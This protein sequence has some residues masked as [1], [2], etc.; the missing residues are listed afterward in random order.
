MCAEH[1]RWG[2]LSVLQNALRNSLTDPEPLL[3]HLLPVKNAVDKIMS[4]GSVEDGSDQ[5]TKQGAGLF[6]RCVVQPYA[7]KTLKAKNA[8]CGPLARFLL[9]FLN[10]ITE[11]MAN[12]V[13]SI[14][15]KNKQYKEE[16]S[17]VEEVLENPKRG[18]RLDA[19]CETMS[20]D[21]LVELLTVDGLESMDIDAVVGLLRQSIAYLKSICPSDGCSSDSSGTFDSVRKAYFALMSSKPLLSH[22]FAQVVHVHSDTASDEDSASGWIAV[23]EG[24]QEA[25]LVTLSDSEYLVLEA[26]QSI[27]EPS[28]S[29]RAFLVG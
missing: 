16:K 19:G 26:L 29:V 25:D 21:I 1:G 27:T 13:W 11:E 22:F 20:V 24:G 23:T 9:W 7:V 12:I 18:L 4:R 3:Q 8:T 28:E 15:L 17:S 2:T 5:I 6:L 14:L 10:G